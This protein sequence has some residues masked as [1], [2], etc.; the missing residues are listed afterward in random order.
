MQ[1]PW[2]DMSEAQP[3]LK[4]PDPFQR[5]P[6]REN[7]CDPF[8]DIAQTEPRPH[9]RLDFRTRVDPACD[10]LQLYRRQPTSD[11]RRSA[12]GEG[13]QPLRHCTGRSS[14]EAFACQRLGRGAA[15]D[16]SAPRMTIAIA[17]KRRAFD[18]DLQS[19]AICS[20]SIPVWLRFVIG[21]GRILLPPLYSGLG[22]F[23]NPI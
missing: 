19:R 21:K 8:H 15:S 3:A 10:H 23:L 1:R 5:I 18:E 14:P 17:R 9:I 22:S 2:R 13:P 20:N 16:R 4:L 12:P 6:Y 11:G 7:R